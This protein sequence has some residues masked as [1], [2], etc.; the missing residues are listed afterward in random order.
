MKRLDA[1]LLKIGDV[2]LTT[3][4]AKVSKAVRFGTGS[5]ISHAMVYVAD[6]SV[7]D[8]T[9]DGVQARNT[10]RLL[11]EDDGPVHV[12]RSR[13]TPSESQLR[14][15]CTFVRG[16]IGTE[17]STK[18]AVRTVLGGGRGWTKKQ[19]C[20]RLVAQAYA[21]AGLALVGDPN[22]CSPEDLK[23]SPQLIEVEGVTVSITDQEAARWEALADMPQMMMDATNLVLA[24]A[25]KISRD[26]Q[27]FDDLDR[28]LIQHPGDDEYLCGL[29]EQSGYLT[30]WQVE[31][32]QN[33]WQYDI[34]LLNAFSAVDPGVDHYCRS[35][36][37]AEENGP[38]RYIVNRGGY[39]QLAKQFGL[40]YFHLKLD[41]Y[42]I[43]TNLHHIRVQTAT[44]WLEERHFPGTA[45][46]PPSYLVP[47]T[48]EWFAALEVWDPPKA[49]MARMAIATGGSVDVCSVCGDDPARDYRLEEP[50][51]PPA[52]V[53]TLRLCDDCL[54]IRRRTGDPF[55]PLP[56]A[57]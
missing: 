42:D 12:L 40:R 57:P 46:V 5:D 33:P 31:K 15:I 11:F 37:A 27:S 55:V 28:Y 2:I 35:V 3:T 56:D 7:I 22:Y 10:Q 25:R 39:A 45:E 6:H 36:L 21:S 30:L 1:D 4:T 16:R 26:I 52:G 48:A 29:L 18:E 43:L 51:R 19:F 47:H 53:D 34:G 41:L 24:G 20:S 54:D 32:E 44:A 49:A 8:A 9:G 50:F 13:Q 23:N 14:E 38:N 17:Y